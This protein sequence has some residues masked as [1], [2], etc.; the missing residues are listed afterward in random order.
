MIWN[1]RIKFLLFVGISQNLER[2]ETLRDLTRKT[3]IE[4][5]HEITR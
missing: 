1:L 5:D 2:L 3:D 4:D